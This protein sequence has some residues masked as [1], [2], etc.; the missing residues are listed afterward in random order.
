MCYANRVLA[1]CREPRSGFEI[2][3]PCPFPSTVIITPRT[4][5]SLFLYIYIC[6]ERDRHR[7]RNRER[8]R[9][10]IA[11]LKR[12]NRILKH[13]HQNRTNIRICEINIGNPETLTTFFSPGTKHLLPS[14][15]FSTR[16]ERDTISTMLTV[17]SDPTTRGHPVVHTWTGLAQVR[18]LT[19][20]VQ[21]QISTNC[22]LSKITQNPQPIAS[23]H[24]VIHISNL[25]DFGCPRGIMVKA[26]NCGIVVREFVLQSRY[27]VHFRANTLGKGMNPLILPPAMGK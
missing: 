5:S 20:F 25:M 22:F 1:L 4:L 12:S 11:V 27:Y 19:R 8:H 15:L 18:K 16:G 23:R 2:D 21:L 24:D 26:M 17:P 7:D 3:S 10:S 13:I 6:R 14:W 9:D